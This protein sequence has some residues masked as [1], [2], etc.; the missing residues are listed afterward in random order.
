[1]FS[2]VERPAISLAKLTW[3]DLASGEEATAPIGAGWRLTFY[4]N[5]VIAAHPDE[6]PRYARRL[7]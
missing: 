1:M 3:L 7:S 4:E 5:K 2:I 6:R